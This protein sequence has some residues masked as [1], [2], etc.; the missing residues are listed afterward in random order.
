MLDGDAGTAEDLFGE[1]I[2][3]FHLAVLLLA[4]GRM[5]GVEHI[6]L[7]RFASDVPFRSLE[8]SVWTLIPFPREIP[9]RDPIK[10]LRWI[11]DNKDRIEWSED[12]GKFVVL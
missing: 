5:H 11:A 3:L 7:N 9:R 2:H 8:S 4:Y 6:L 1:E 12:A 10:A